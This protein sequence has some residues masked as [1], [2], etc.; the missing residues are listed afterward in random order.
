MLRETHTEKDLNT[1]R[2]TVH[3]GEIN[4]LEKVI[5]RN[6]DRCF[7]RVYAKKPNSYHH[8]FTKK[9]PYFHFIFRI[10][11][12]PVSVIELR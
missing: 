12:N 5:D 4:N 9:T 6:L 8:E 10:G 2:E 1:K 7:G 11:Q 3:N